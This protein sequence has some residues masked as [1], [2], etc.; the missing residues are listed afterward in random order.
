MVYQLPLCLGTNIR[1]EEQ[2]EEGGG[3]SHC[4]KNLPSLQSSALVASKIIGCRYVC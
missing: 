2:N 3:L 4:T 1:P